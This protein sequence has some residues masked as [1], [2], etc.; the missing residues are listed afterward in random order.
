MNSHFGL[1]NVWA[2]GDLVT[3]SVAVLLLTRSLASWMVII[4][5]PLDFEISARCGWP[6]L[7]INTRTVVLPCSFMRR[8]MAG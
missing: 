1:A 5:K 4:I 3:K 7:P 6:S 2:Q 8:L